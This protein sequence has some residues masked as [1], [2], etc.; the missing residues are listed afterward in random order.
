MKITK[1]E[2][3]G[4]ALI[5]LIFIMMSIVAVV[6]F[7]LT[8]IVSFSSEQ[9][10]IQNGYS[11]FPS[12]WSVDAYKYVF[13]NDTVFSAYGVTIFVTVVG[14]VLSVLTCS[15]CA[16]GISNP[17]VKYR[18]AIAMFLYIPTVFGAGMVPW[19][20]VVTKVLNL[21][22]SIWGLILPYLISTF[23]IFLLRN[24]FKAVPSSLLESA[25]LDGARPFR[26]FWQVVLPLSTPVLATVT[27]FTALG[28]W[29]D[30]YLAL[31]LIDDQKLYPVQYMLYKIQS[32]IQYMAQTGGQMGGAA[33]PTTTVQIATMFVTIG[34]IILLYPFVQKYFVKGI[35]IG[36]VKG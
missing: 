21:K 7:V 5:H 15:L 1:S 14:T 11:F 29:N 18:N 9:S 27:L 34:P 8:L 3:L 25:E 6:P 33:V 19:Y 10:V 2:R 16:F 4:N 31:W 26:I 22:N 35:M 13:S 36:A 30:W 23:N 20:L 12:E 28:Y 17:K 24:N 32:L